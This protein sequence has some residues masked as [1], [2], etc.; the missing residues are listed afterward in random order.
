[1]NDIAAFVDSDVVISSFLP[2]KGAAYLLINSEISVALFISSFSVKELLRVSE[3][4]K[5]KISNVAK[6]EKQLDFIDIETSIEHI[7]KDYEQYVL[8]INDVHT[9]FGAHK[10]KCK[11]LV[12]YNLRDYKIQKIKN[13]LG[14]TVLTPGTFLQFLRGLELV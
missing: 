7:S 13:D 4:L 12:T 5:F 14:I 9:V 1:M 2:D 11:F 10:A 8:D 6:I 3:K